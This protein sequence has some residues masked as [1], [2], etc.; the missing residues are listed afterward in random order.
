MLALYPSDRSSILRGGSLLGSPLVQNYISV[1][2]SGPTGNF[3]SKKDF[4]KAIETNASEVYLYGILISNPFQGY[5]HTIPDNT[6]FLVIGPHPYKEDG[7]LATLEV[8]RG[9]LRVS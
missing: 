9:I 5:A 3:A 7:W 4:K 1:S 2:A 8:R 6:K